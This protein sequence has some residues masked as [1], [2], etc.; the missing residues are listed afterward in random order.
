MILANRKPQTEKIAATKIHKNSF[1]SNN[2]SSGLSG[3]T[4]IHKNSFSIDS[5]K[6]ENDGFGKIPNQE[7]NKRKS[8]K[9]NQDKTSDIDKSNRRAAEKIDKKLES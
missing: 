1:S 8:P 3:G 9:A 2:S 5:G 7:V 6:N 4:K